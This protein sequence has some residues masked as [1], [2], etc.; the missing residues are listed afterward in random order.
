MQTMFPEIM[1]VYVPRDIQLRR[2][3]LRDGITE[4]QAQL[5]LLA[6]MP[7]ED[8]RLLAD[9]LVDNSE[10]LEATEQQIDKFWRRKGLS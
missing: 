3:M 5:R 7:I 1:V 4:E 6:Q 2:L 9:V 8:K 10:S